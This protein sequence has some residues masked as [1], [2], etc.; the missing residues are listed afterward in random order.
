[1][2]GVIAQPS[3]SLNS[4]HIFLQQVVPLLRTAGVFRNAYP[5]TRLLDHLQG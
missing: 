2:D 3:G 1:M 4:L 5:V